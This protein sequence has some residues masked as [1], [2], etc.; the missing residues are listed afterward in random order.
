MNLLSRLF[1]GQ[2]K[3]SWLSALGPITVELELA[4]AEDD[5]L[6]GTGQSTTWKI[7][8]P[9]IL[10]DVVDL[11]PD[12]T[13]SYV[14]HLEEGKSLPYSFGS[15]AAIEH[16][17]PP[18]SLA[19]FSINQSRSFSRLNTL[20]VVFNKPQTN[21]EREVNTFVGKTNDTTITAGQDNLNF[22]FSLGG[23]RYPTYPSE[24]LATHRYC[25]LDALGKSVSDAHTPGNDLKVYRKN[26][27]ILGHN[28]EKAHPGSGAEYSGISTRNGDLLTLFFKNIGIAGATTGTQV[29]KCLVVN[30]FF[31]VM[32]VSAQGCDV[33]D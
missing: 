24:K 29:N 14:K 17:I 19:N 18:S 15:F 7:S 2:S 33:L 3:Y 25:Y 27:L 1:C 31:Q 6:G 20:F 21:T 22:Y 8:N 26:K 4:A 5:F 13:N 32:R 9:V 11:S 30:H 28:L 23:T 16:A 12:L 10:G